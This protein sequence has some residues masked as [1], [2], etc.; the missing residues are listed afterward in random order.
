MPFVV[1][2]SFNLRY[3]EE[4]DKNVQPY[5]L[6]DLITKLETTFRRET[7]GQPTLLLHTSLP[8]WVEAVSSTSTHGLY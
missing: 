6:K 8:V 3:E 7:I 4:I 1:V 5:F 2:Y